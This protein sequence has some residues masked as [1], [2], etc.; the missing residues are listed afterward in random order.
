MRR[1]IYLLRHAD[2]AYVGKDGRPVRPDEATLT[3]EGEKQAERLAE[4]LRPVPFDRAITSGL[5]RTLETARRILAARGPAI[6]SWPDLAEIRGGRLRDI[7]PEAL[8]AAL[9]SAFRGA[10][11]EAARF[12]GG[13][14]IGQLFDRVLPAIQRLIDARDWDCAL[15]VLHGGVNRAWLSWALT[16]ARTFLGHLEQAPGC[17]N[18]LDFG[19]GWVVRTINL[20]LWDPLSLDGRETT[21]ERLYQELR[22]I[23]R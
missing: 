4:V 17:I 16:G 19:E 10:A 18:V 12:L 8:E 1:R 20:R 22:G 3:P 14:S 23:P 7:S 5:P 9:L 13:E 6:E 15:A 2:V 21:M 11:P